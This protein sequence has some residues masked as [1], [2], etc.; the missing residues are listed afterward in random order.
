MAAWR[1]AA[2]SEPSVARRVSS[3]SRRSAVTSVT[4]VTGRRRRRMPGDSFRKSASFRSCSAP[5]A[6]GVA[7]AVWNVTG[8]TWTVSMRESSLKS[9]LPMRLNGSVTR[10]IVRLR[11]AAHMASLYSKSGA[12]RLPRTGMLSLMLP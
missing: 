4:V 7:R 11:T 10:R 9:T 2:S 3:A 8:S 1:R 5:A 6:V 12:D